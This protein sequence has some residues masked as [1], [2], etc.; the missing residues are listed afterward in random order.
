MLPF[1]S[2]FCLSKGPFSSVS[3][4]RFPHF[5]CFSLVRIVAHESRQGRSTDAIQSELALHCNRL[6]DARK[7]ICLAIVNGSTARILALVADQKRPDQICEEIGYGRTFEGVSGVTRESC[8]LVGDRL[9]NALKEARGIDQPK[10][11]PAIEEFGTKR[12]PLTLLNRDSLPRFF[13][14]R[15]RGDRI[16]LEFEETQR[17]GCHTVVGLLMRGLRDEVAQGAN[18]TYLCDQL[19]ARHLVSFVNATKA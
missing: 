4:T 12:N 1:L 2:S 3:D 7:D 11:H 14:R 18:S 9:L 5:E 17:A 6:A 16:C 19:E 10:Q 13:R 8:Q 15:M